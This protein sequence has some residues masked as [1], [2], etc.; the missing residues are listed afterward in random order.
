M[1][2][3]SVQHSPRSFAPEPRPRLTPVEP[4]AGRPVAAPIVHADPLAARPVWSA[5]RYALPGPEQAALRSSVWRELRRLRALSVAPAVWA[6]TH[7]DGIATQLELLRSRVVDGGGEASVAS[8]GHVHRN[9][10]ELQSRVNRACEHLWDDLLNATDWVESQVS[11]SR[12][13]P[14]ELADAVDELRAAYRTTRPGEVVAS[15]TGRHVTD[16]LHALAD[17]VGRGTVETDRL[18]A[19][20]RHRLSVDRVWRRRDG[21]VTLVASLRPCPSLAWELALHDFESWAYR[22]SAR[23]APIEHGTIVVPVPPG[24]LDAAV[25][26]IRARISS[27]EQTLG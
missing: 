5:F 2:D 21:Q 15:V 9:D 4:L 25:A 16:R 6:V 1:T 12:L 10:V 8:V 19:P 14:H 18:P 23:R 3:L 17:L 13:G 20:G 11:A 26:A 27:F 7:H 22:P 24:D